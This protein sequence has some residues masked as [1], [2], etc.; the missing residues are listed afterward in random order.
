MHTYSIFWE[1]KIEPENKQK[2]EYE[3]GLNGSWNLL[4]QTSK[5]YKGSYL[6]QSE[7]N[8]YIY[9]LIDTWVNKTA[10]EGFIKKNKNTYERLSIKFEYLYK[11]EKRIGAFNNL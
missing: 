8:P 5:S 3:Y 2:F 4:F 10:Y 6:Y 11:T 7:D 1:Y 9:L